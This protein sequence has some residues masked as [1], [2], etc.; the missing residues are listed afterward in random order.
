MNFIK[1]HFIPV[2]IIL[3]IGFPFSLFF[4]RNFELDFLSLS[5][6]SIVFFKTFTQSILST[7]FSFIHA[8]FATMALLSFS[9][10]RFYSVLEW[11]YLIP[12]ILPSI[13]IL[14]G[15]LNILEWS[16]VS[17]FGLFPLILCHAMSFS[18]AISVILARAI[19]HKCHSIC[20][21]AK[22]HGVHSY[23]LFFNLIWFALRK[24]T[25]LVLFTVFCFCFTSLNIPLVIGGSYW[26]TIEVTIYE[27]MKDLSQW[28]FALGLIILEVLFIFILSLFI[29]TKQIFSLSKSQPVQF[30]HISYLYLFIGLLPLILIGFG[31]FEG[32]FYLPKVIQMEGI[33]EMTINSLILALSVGIGVI[34]FLCL[35]SLFPYVHYLQ[36]FL[37]G[38]GAPSLI[39]TSFA[40]LVFFL[41]YIY[42]S[43][44]LGLTILFVPALY[45]WVAGGLL[46]SLESQILIARTLGVSQYN[47]FFKVILPQCSSSLFL[48]GSVASIWALGDFAF[49]GVT[50]GH[51]TNLSILAQQLIHQYR[52]EEGLAVIF[53]LLFLGFIIFF[54][55]YWISSILNLYLTR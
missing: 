40:F 7:F 46:K 52:W 12:I 11:L 36:K 23:K 18:G 10:S 2:S 30:T 50:A 1:S 32:I 27:Q 35:I 55:F 45:R 8:V 26:Q 33:L 13:V 24:D 31:L 9:R 20:D 49:T 19:M 53:I 51:K 54:I 4:F 15:V 41:D 14:G 25:I 43:W 39:L 21:W 48:L 47:I 29:S 22:V 16:Y 44:I 34:L 28:S 17:P 5:E 6:T 3:I 38:Y 42:F 37:I